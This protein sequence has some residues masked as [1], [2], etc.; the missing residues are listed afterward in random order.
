[1]AF[2]RF[3]DDACRVQKYLEETTNVGKYLLNVPG[4]GIHPEFINDPYVKIQKWGANLSN[5]K[6]LLENELFGLTRQLNRDTI[7]ENNYVDNLNANNLYNKNNYTINNSEITSQSRVTHPAWAFRELDSLDLP[8]NFKYL[9]LN[10]Q[11]NVCIPFH[12]N[13]SSRIVEKDYFKN[14]N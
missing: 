6:T 1:M 8:N 4:N 9:H 13:I 10:P 3:H 11:E 7:K 5:N 2:T 12:N 14:N